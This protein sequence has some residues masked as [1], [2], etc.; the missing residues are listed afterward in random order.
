M[1]KATGIDSI[2]VSI[3]PM[4]AAYKELKSEDSLKKSL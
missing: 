3:D 4:D 2:T 1:S